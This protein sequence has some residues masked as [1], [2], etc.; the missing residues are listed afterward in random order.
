MV[1][2][3]GANIMKPSS[4]YWKQKSQWKRDKQY[5]TSLS[6][7]S[8]LT[9]DIIISLFAKIYGAKTGARREY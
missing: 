5:G 4:V 1:K 3:N 8:S 9:Y 6:L 7:S 2:A